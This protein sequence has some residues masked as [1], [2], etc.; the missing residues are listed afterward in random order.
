MNLKEK[1]M[2]L[3]AAAAINIPFVRNRAS[4][5]GLFEYENEMRDIVPLFHKFVEAAVDVYK[6]GLD[7]LPPLIELSERHVEFCKRSELSP[8]WRVEQF[9]RTQ[10]RVHPTAAGGS[11][12]DNTSESGGG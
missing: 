10:H 8:Q 1:N 12:S 2:L 11:T 5:K 3:V 6:D 9:L 7:P 4:S